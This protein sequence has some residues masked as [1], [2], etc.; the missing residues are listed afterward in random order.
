MQ[1]G[2]ALEGELL[3]CELCVVGAGIGGLNAL[4]SATCYL[5]PSDRVVLVDR[6]AAPGGM[7][8][9]TY[10]HVRL[11][12]P[13][14]LF[15][16]GNIPWKKRM[17]RAHL[18]DKQEI[19]QHFAHCLAELSRRVALQCRFGHSYLGHRET[20][21]AV[22]VDVQDGSSQRPIRIRA[23][24]LIRAPGLDI[25]TALPLALSSSR[26]RS[27]SPDAGDFPDPEIA[28][29]DAP[30]V[31]VGGGKTAMDTAH[32]L[33]R[34][35]P[36][37]DIRMLIGNGTMFWNRNRVYT[38][39]WRRWLGGIVAFEYFLDAVMQFDGSN[40]EEANQHRLHVYDSLSLADQPKHFFLSFI[41][42]E[43]CA[44][45][46]NG[47]SA[48]VEDHL[49][50]VVDSDSGPQICLRKRGVQ[51]VPAGTCFVNCTGYIANAPAPYEPYVSESG[52]VLS[53]N[54]SSLPF[55][56]TSFSGYY[57]GH[58]LYR[59]QL[60]QVPLYAIDLPDIVAKNK[61]AL[62]SIAEATV[63]LNVLRLMKALP[64]RVFNDCLLDFNRW[65][66]LPRRLPILL[67]YM[68]SNDRI[69][70][71]CEKSLERLRQ[72]SGIQM[73]VLPHVAQQRPKSGVS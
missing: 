55:F 17:P 11:H 33:I 38:E 36:G 18:A 8:Q 59:N 73:G 63:V 5:K 57:L 45:I 71:H 68:I 21:D 67:R 37:R 25:R 9:D 72:D 47:L 14:R 22:E 42:E 58:L 12:Q 64:M 61:A 49:E 6:R 66:P 51:N 20:A 35:F 48:I 39:G 56:L 27:V 41:S 34:R 26:V 43:E 29:S 24:R 13:H 60:L 19:N 46:R 15:T 16:V 52:R 28:A 40:V 2:N 44:L 70:T 1:H 53:L 31:I 10:N 32:C 3:D 50:D 69:A 4:H 23:R 62:G 30:I 65:F 7:W 54:Q